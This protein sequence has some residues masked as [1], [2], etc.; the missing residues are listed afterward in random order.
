MDAIKIQAKGIKRA[1]T[2]N[3]KIIKLLNQIFNNLP[4]SI[5]KVYLNI[6]KKTV[7]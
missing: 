6:K 4:K 2:K 7:F 5:K 3:Y 1:N